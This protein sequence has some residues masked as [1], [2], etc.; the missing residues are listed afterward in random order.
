M[1]TLTLSPDAR[2][3]VV[4]LAIVLVMGLA[5][6]ALGVV[7]APK[8]HIAP[9]PRVVDGEPDDGLEECPAC[10]GAGT[11]D[12]T[13]AEDR[14]IAFDTTCRTCGGVGRVTGVWF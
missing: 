8:T 13:D 2:V 14:V 9:P 7:M 6:V 5:F 1:T 12:L 3:M 10:G 11:V 4:Q